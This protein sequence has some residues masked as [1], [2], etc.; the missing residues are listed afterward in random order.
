M[1][2]YTNY[3]K[4]QNLKLYLEHLSDF[5]RYPCSMLLRR[6]HSN[7]KNHLEIEKVLDDIMENFK[8]ICR[9]MKPVTEQKLF[10]V[11]LERL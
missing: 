4:T 7:T 5:W 3:L 2:A 11:V 9:D 6:L 8:E 1:P 10:Y